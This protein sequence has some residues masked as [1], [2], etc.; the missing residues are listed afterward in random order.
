M[1]NILKR[2]KTMAND[3]L[4][5]I[6]S[7]LSDIVAA[8]GTAN[9]VDLT[10]L[11]TEIMAEVTTQTDALITALSSTQAELAGTQNALNT[12]QTSVSADEG[13]EA[14]LVAR[15][16]QLE[17]A[18][19]HTV[20]SLATGNSVDATAAATAALAGAP[21][22]SASTASGSTLAAGTDATVTG[23]GATTTAGS[24]VEQAADAAPKV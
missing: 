2:I 16:T 6:D 15:V 21:V 4:T 19:T 12:L 22:D 18:L 17:T 7:A 8:H 23:D 11:H 20:K 13:V 14:S 10:N 3:F 1:F 9:N 5:S 24:A